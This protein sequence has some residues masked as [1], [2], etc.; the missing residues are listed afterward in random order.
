MTSLVEKTEFNLYP[1]PES[2]EPFLD[3]NTNGLCSFKSYIKSKAFNRR[4]DDQIRGI[5]YPLNASYGYCIKLNDFLNFLEKN[6]SSE[7]YATYIGIINRSQPNV[8]LISHQIVSYLKCSGSR[9][10]PGNYHNNS[11]QIGCINQVLYIMNHLPKYIDEIPVY[12]YYLQYFLDGNMKEI[13]KSQYKVE[14]YTQSITPSLEL[15]YSTINPE[16][17][18]ETNKTSVSRISFITN[19]QTKHAVELRDNDDS[20]VIKKEKLRDLTEKVRNLDDIKLE[21]NLLKETIRTLE[22]NNS[23]LQ[24][25]LDNKFD[26]VNNSIDTLYSTHLTRTEKLEEEI[27]LLNDTI[28]SLTS[29]NAEYKVKIQNQ[30]E[31]IENDRSI[32]EKTRDLQGF[33]TTFLEHI[34][35]LEKEIE[36]LKTKEDEYKSQIKDQQES[37]KTLEFNYNQVNLEI[38]SHKE[39]IE[40]LNIEL[41][42]EKQSCESK[43]R[44]IDSKNNLVKELQERITKLNQN[45]TISNEINTTNELKILNL[46]DDINKT[47]TEV[48]V[49]EK[50]HNQVISD[51]I[52]KYIKN[53]YGK[54]ITLT[55]VMFEYLNKFYFVKIDNRLFE[56]IDSESLKHIEITNLP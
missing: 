3:T 14:P 32:I 25:Q 45:L 1:V 35:S 26:S 27:K 37:I 34:L 39:K 10:F 38:F 24:S 5:P 29:I 31:K 44:I 20:T 52:S 30:Q 36:S 19:N 43:D 40:N 48:I 9:L 47:K 12:I 46:E 51:I 21:N 13:Q 23:Y 22:I 42:I 18:P 7:I 33:N 56:V 4:P 49:N 54:D 8:A 15:L 6:E 41:T 53:K 55:A 11:I 2:I 28:L 17:K 16:F 50:R